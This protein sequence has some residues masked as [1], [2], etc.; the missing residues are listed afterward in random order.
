MK[1]NNMKYNLILVLLLAIAIGGCEDY[2]DYKTD[3]E[4]SSVYFPYQQPLRTVVMGEGLD[5]EVGVVLGGRRDNQ[6]QETVEYELDISLLAGT[7]LKLLPED[8]Y[9]LSDD[10]QMLIPAGSIHGRVTVDLDSAA[11][12]DDP[13]SYQTTYALP[14]RIVEASV[15]SVLRGDYNEATGEY[16]I[17][18]KDYTI[19]AVKYI[20][21]YHGT[22]YHKGVDYTY[23]AEGNPTDTSNYSFANLVDHFTWDLQTIGPKRV[24]TT[25]IGSLSDGDGGMYV[26]NLHVDGSQVT[27]E[28]AAG[29]VS[30]I[31]T[32]EEESASYDA[33]EQTFYLEYSY[34][35]SD[36]LLHEVTDTLVFRD[37]GMKFETW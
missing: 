24:Q 19:V 3:F 31:T 7:G 22:Y 4:Y 21:P 32:L 8:Y 37:R 10:S 5:F 27:I 23:D 20:N 35:D 1:T 16:E 29:S 33:Q 36:D 2:E 14:F 13:E 9:T 30:D 26:M 34:T 17:K 28:N 11:F 15:D 25:G 12:V 18:P 6:Q